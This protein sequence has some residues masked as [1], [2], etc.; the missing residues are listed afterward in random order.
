MKHLILRGLLAA[1]LATLPVSAFAGCA[2]LVVG[3]YQKYSEIYLCISD[4][5]YDGSQGTFV[6]GGCPPNSRATQMVG[7]E[8]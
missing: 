8:F 4:A 1:S 6:N 3:M 7:F 2:G 5:N